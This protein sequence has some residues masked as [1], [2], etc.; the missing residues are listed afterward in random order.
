[1]T[2]QFPASLEGDA[3]IEAMLTL[4]HPF[5]APIVFVASLPIGTP[6]APRWFAVT[7]TQ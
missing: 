6:A 2:P 4:P 5:Y 3:D 7:G 1:M